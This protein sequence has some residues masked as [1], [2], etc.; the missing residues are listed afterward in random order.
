MNATTTKAAPLEINLLTLRIAATNSLTS[1]FGN[2][3]GVHLAK[4]RARNDAVSARTDGVLC[5]NDAI[6]A[7]LT[8]STVVCTS[9]MSTSGINHD[10]QHVTAINYR[11]I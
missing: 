6:Q 7:S 9:T 4:Q 10:S 11:K 2:A 8:A 1:F 3:A 5:S